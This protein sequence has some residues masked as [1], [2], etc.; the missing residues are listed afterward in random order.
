MKNNG[1]GS[2]KGMMEDQRNIPGFDVV[3]ETTLAASLALHP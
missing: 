1:M 2:D 3:C